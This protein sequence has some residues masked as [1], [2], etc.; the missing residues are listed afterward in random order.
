M[1]KAIPSINAELNF[2][3]KNKHEIYCVSDWVQTSI[4][5]KMTPVRITAIH[6][7]GAIVSNSSDINYKV[8]GVDKI[9]ENLYFILSKS[10]E[11]YSTKT[12]LCIQYAAI[13]IEI[14]N[15]I[16]R[17]SID[18]NLLKNATIRI[19]GKWHVDYKR[20][21]TLLK[22]AG[23][24]WGY[25]DFKETDDV[26]YFYPGFEYKQFIEKHECYWEALH[27]KLDALIKMLGKMDSYV[28]GGQ[29]TTDEVHAI[30]N[31][32]KDNKDSATLYI[33]YSWS[34][35]N[36][37]DT[38]CQDLYKANIIFNR[39]IYNCEY[40]DNIKHFE[41]E[42]GNGAKVLAYINDEYLKSI[43]CMYELALVFMHGN[44]EKRLYPIV[45]NINNRD[46]SFHKELHDYWNSQYQKKKT[47]LNELPSG[48]SLQAIKELGYCDHIIR[49]LPKIVNYISEVNTLTV[50]QLSANHFK[51]LFEDI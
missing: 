41:E 25:K 37:I 19:N 47:I 24:N 46:A 30:T 34:A 15:A 6:H 51:K 43:N 10:K 13:L 5:G 26:C 49:E 11:T 1:E 42:I 23:K 8:L 28:N 18:K 31:T 17:L 12:A 22:E 45:I 27:D 9:L 20:W 2:L 4:E 33:S 29:T 38:L 7:D 14:D 16:V 39:D 35:S 3:D 21:A 50:E 32:K 40:R 44:V 36:E 48:A